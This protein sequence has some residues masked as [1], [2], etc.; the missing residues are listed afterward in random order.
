MPYYILLPSNRSTVAEK[1]FFN[2]V[3]FKNDVISKTPYSQ[4]FITFSVL[5][6]SNISRIVVVSPVLLGS[7]EF[8]LI[9]IICTINYN[10]IILVYVCI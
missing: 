5:V 8:V 2:V 10:S 3:D 4:L 1:K 9:Q 7:P 6:F